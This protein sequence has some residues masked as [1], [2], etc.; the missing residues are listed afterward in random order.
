VIRCALVLGVL[1]WG[2]PAHAG[3]ES[4]A[5]R[6]ALLADLASPRL[7]VRIDAFRVLDGRADVPTV[8]VAVAGVKRVL[9]DRAELL[10]RV[11]REAES[12]ESARV[13]VFEAESRVAAARRRRASAGRI[14]LLES[15]QRR[16]AAYQA[17]TY[18]TLQATRGELRTSR[19]LLQRAPRHL[20]ALLRRLED[21]ERR[22]ALLLLRTTL[23]EGDEPEAWLTWVDTLVAS[24]RHDAAAELERMVGSEAQPGRLRALALDGLAGLGEVRASRVAIPHLQGDLA[25][26]WHLVA[27]AIATLRAL[28]RKEGIPALIAFLG[29]SELGRL[30]GDAHAALVALTHRRE[31]PYA[32]PWER[33]WQE[34]G[35]TFVVPPSEPDPGAL[36]GSSTTA[37]YGIQTWSDR[38][39]FVLDLSGSMWEP[40]DGGRR[41]DIALAELR[42]T[43]GTLDPARRF[44]VVWFGTQTGTWKAEPVP[45]SEHE[46]RQL[47]R[48]ARD[49]GQ[50]GNTNAFGALQLGFDLARAG[51]TRP[52]VDTLF[53]LTDGAAN[54]G[55]VTAT[56]DVLAEVRVW[57]RLERVQLHAVGVGESDPALL[58]GLARTGGGSYVAR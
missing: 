14:R 55:V 53:F 56:A 51:V 36:E 20:G 12:F 46:K 38:I 42:G 35:P 24:N 43:V 58:E 7:E 28:R 23:A 21:I 18:A 40:T 17:D 8:G 11:D 16:A 33:W 4:D 49:V 5:D 50:R 54:A 22:S 27:T 6:A 10:R 25:T 39:G 41:I 29:R 37:F 15:A 19:G 57:C 2:I 52:L 47:A 30:R 3:E 31:G 13:Q 44:A 32:A 48:W 26:G 34:A 1:L 9:R 45:A